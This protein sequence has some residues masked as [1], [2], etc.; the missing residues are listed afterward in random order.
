MVSSM[1][2]MVMVVA[3][4]LGNFTLV[5]TSS[6][7]M[8]SGELK[9]KVETRLNKPLD[10]K[11]TEEMGNTILDNLSAEF[12]IMYKASEDLKKLE[13]QCD[14]LL[15]NSI[16]EPIQMTFWNKLDYSDRNIPK[17]LFVFKQPN[18][19]KYNII[20]IQT[21]AINQGMTVMGMFT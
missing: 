7:Q 15:S 12:D 1:L 20:N 14:M 19:D 5:P 4:L 9:F 16:D 8:K 13:M 6:W 17:T 18:D 2:S 21:P 10:E 11:L 3:L